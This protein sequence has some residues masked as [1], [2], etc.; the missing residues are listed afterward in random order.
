M[1]AICQKCGGF[2]AKAKR[3]CPSCKMVPAGEEQLATA[4]LLS[5]RFLPNEQ[6]TQVGSQ[7]RAGQALQHHNGAFF[8]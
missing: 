8:F 7:I 6:L 4:L 2:K 3:R 1:I 5:V